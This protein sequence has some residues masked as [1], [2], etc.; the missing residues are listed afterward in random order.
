MFISGGSWIYFHILIPCKLG[1]TCCVTGPSIQNQRLKMFNVSSSVFSLLRAGSTTWIRSSQYL[2]P[3]TT[4]RSLKTVTFIIWTGTGC[5]TRRVSCRAVYA[6]LKLV[7]KAAFALTVVGFPQVERRTARKNSSFWATGIH[8]CWR[9]SVAS[10]KVTE[11][12]PSLHVA[13]SHVSVI[14]N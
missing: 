4:R 14:C 8:P 13:P 12:V 9:K 5:S 7:G 2:F 1:L 6:S 10:C 11:T 3:T